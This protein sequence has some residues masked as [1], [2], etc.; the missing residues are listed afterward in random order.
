MASLLITWCKIEREIREAVTDYIFG[1]LQ[2]S[3]QI[4]T[5]AP[6][7]KN[8]CPLK[9]N[10]DKPRQHIKK[11]RHHFA[12]KGMYSQNYGFSSSYI[13]MWELDIKNAECLRVDAFELCCWRRF[14]SPLDSMEIK[15]VNP[16]RNQH[17]IFIGRTDAEFEAPIL[18]PADGKNYLIGK[19]PDA[20]KDWKQEEKGETEDKIVRYYHWLNGQE[21]EQTMGHSRRRQWQPTPVL[22][23]GKSHGWRSLV[24]RSPWG[25]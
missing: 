9:E 6:K 17:G 24:G 23:P 21:F 20:G 13:Q 2:K 22:L 16:Q 3:L 5:A 14:E 19:D 18:W 10:Y 4:V 8:A 7:L 12:D 25:R 1:G 11:Q 15:L